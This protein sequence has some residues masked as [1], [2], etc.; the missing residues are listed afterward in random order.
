MVIIVRV[1]G[2]LTWSWRF[3]R[4][5]VLGVVLWLWGFWD[6]D[7][8]T[9]STLLWRGVLEPLMCWYRVPWMTVVWSDARG[10]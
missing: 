7:A 5:G 6:S 3:M 10:E 4:G 1:C 9:C 2:E 8:R